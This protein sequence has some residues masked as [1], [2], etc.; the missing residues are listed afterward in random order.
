MATAL[1]KDYKIQPKER[2]GIYSFNKW[3]WY[4]IQLA[5]SL[6]D[7]I[8]VNVN[9]SYKSEELG[10]TLDKVRIKV[11]FISDAFKN[12]NYL[13]VLRETAPEIN[14]NNVNPYHLKS[15]K[16]PYLHSVVRIN[17]P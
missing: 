3:E 8:V 13:D 12:S 14:D 11:L 4:I 15:K 17:G 7:A 5:C 9:P 1:I 16:F 10:Y 6:V 2:I